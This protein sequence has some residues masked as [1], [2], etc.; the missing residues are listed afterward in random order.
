LSGH[1]LL[2]VMRASM[3]L[4]AVQANA[5]ANVPPTKTLG[6][7]LQRKRGGFLPVRRF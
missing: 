5:R 6:D 7:M 2:A 4:Q 3:R 1:T